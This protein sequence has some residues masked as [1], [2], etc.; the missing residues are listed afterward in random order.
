MGSR[1]I[2]PSVSLQ[3]PDMAY[4]S[5]LCLQGL[6]ELAAKTY[7]ARRSMQGSMD[8]SD[9]FALADIILASEPSA[10]LENRGNGTISASGK[11][12][13]SSSGTG[14]NGG[15]SNGSSSKGSISSKAKAQPDRRARLDQM[16]SM[17]EEIDAW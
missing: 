2:P 11:E 16:P 4:V 6:F 5:C 7:A 13:V 3:M 8:G 9:D 12:T 15:T 10:T 14:S 1:L 17:R